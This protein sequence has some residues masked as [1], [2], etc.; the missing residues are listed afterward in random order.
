MS[1]KERQIKALEN[2]ARHL[3]QEKDGDKIY[4]ALRRLEVGLHRSATNACNG[5]LPMYMWSQKERYAKKRVKEIF[6][7]EVPGFFV[8]GDPRG[9]A[10]KIDDKIERTVLYPAGIYLH[11]DWGG[12]AI[13][14]PEPE[15]N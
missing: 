1:Q 6:G 5:D 11:R 13:L 7:A 3:G 9:Y 14:A 10:L 8:N 2:L 12:Y 4:R 15:E